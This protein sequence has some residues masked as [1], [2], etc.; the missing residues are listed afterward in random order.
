MNIIGISAYYHDS[1]ACLIKNGKIITSVQEER[2]SRIK[3]D[4]SFPLNSIKYCLEFAN[5]KP[6]DIHFIAFYDNWFLKQKRSIDNLLTNGFSSFENILN[7]SENIFNEKDLIKNLTNF[8]NL[9]ESE[10]QNKLSYVQHHYSF[11]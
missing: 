9:S 4:R 11:H 2:F 7:T 6:E 8:L 3:H 1:A 5:L 10:I